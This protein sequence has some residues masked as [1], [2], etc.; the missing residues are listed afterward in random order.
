MDEALNEGFKNLFKEFVI[1]MGDNIK[2]GPHTQ[3]RKANLIQDNFSKKSTAHGLKPGNFD[4]NPDRDALACF[5]NFHRIAKLK[6]WSKKLQLNA[7][8]LYLEGF[9]H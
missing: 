2:K 1:A 3:H 9:A 4:G 5:D 8:P 6:N 7:F